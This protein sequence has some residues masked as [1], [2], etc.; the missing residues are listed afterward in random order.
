[1]NTDPQAL[2][3][4]RPLSPGWPLPPP[5][6]HRRGPGAGF[7]ESRLPGGVSLGWKRAQEEAEAEREQQQEGRGRLVV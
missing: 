4:P 6:D 3:V 2:G 1:M 7:S 5:A